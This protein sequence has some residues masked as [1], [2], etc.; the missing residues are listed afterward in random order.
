MRGATSREALAACG[1]ETDREPMLACH[2]RLA[3]TERLLA[4]DH[5]TTA[6][7]HALD[8]RFVRPA[9]VAT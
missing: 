6:I 3:A 5:E 2:T 7:V 4:T 8:G 9:P 1:S